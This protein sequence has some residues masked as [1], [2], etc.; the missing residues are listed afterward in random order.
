MIQKK[1]LTKSG[2]K[3]IVSI[4]ASINTGLSKTLKSDFN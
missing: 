4:K 2:I 1:H 3:Q